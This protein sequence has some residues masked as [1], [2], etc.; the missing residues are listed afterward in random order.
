[1]PPGWLAVSLEEP[2]WSVPRCAGCAGRV[3]P[4]IS[5]LRPANPSAAVSP[6]IGSCQPDSRD[7]PHR[8]IWSRAST[9]THSLRGLISGQG[10]TRYVWRGDTHHHRR[11]EGRPAGSWPAS[12]ATAVPSAYLRGDLR[13]S[14]GGTATWVFGRGAAHDRQ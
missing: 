4:W 12:G 5:T 8:L 1:M 13:P 3:D 6:W 10:R 11:P 9:A 7:R 2:F 14:S